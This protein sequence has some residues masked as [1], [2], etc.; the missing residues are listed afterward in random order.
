MAKPPIIIS[1]GGVIGELAKNSIDP[2]AQQKI[3]DNLNRINDDEL[4]EGI[5]IIKG[6]NKAPCIYWRLKNEE[7]YN[8]KFEV[9]IAR[10]VE[11]KGREGISVNDLFDL[12]DDSIE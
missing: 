12:F 2:D 1:N 5:I 4:T 8:K 3:K 7:P 10:D 6:G 11:K 9:E